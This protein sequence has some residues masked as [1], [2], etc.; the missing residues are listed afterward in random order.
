[1]VQQRTVK[2][3]GMRGVR[4]GEGDRGSMKNEK[5]REQDKVEWSGERRGGEG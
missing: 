2:E 4:E 1:M 5:E 3:G